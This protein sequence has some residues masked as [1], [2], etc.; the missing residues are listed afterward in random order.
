MNV[1]FLISLG[2]A[3]HAKLTALTFVCDSASANIAM[4]KMVGQSSP[5]NI[6]AD[7]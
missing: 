2:V 4:L 6:L 5:A 3:E 1:Y 7:A